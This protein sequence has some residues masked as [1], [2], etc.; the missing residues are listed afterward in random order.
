[1]NT[2]KIGIN[3]QE[4]KEKKRYSYNRFSFSRFLFLKFFFLFT[5][6]KNVNPLKVQLNVLQM[7]FNFL[8][9]FSKKTRESL[10]S[11]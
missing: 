2:H 1:M 6:S 5:G 3:D 9:M 7:Q 4:R 11:F 8:F 10:K